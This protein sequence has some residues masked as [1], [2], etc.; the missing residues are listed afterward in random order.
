MEITYTSLYENNTAMA[1]IMKFKV[2]KKNE[3]ERSNDT[4][5]MEHEEEVKNVIGEKTVMQRVS[6][7]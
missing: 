6:H 7:D 4:Y 2:M 3:E 1:N 5:K